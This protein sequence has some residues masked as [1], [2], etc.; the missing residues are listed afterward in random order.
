MSS[1]SQTGTL[2][3]SFSGSLPLTAISSSSSPSSSSFLS[4]S[5]PSPSSNDNNDD[6]MPPIS[7]S[8][9][10]LFGFL[11]TFLALFVGFM[12]CGY[13]SRRAAQLR[14]AGARTQFGD[15]GH[16]KSVKMKKPQLWDVRIAEKPG[17]EEWK[18]MTPLSA[19][20]LRPKISKKRSTPLPNAASE[21]PPALL[22]H[23][24]PQEYSPSFLFSSRSFGRPFNS[25]PPP[26]PPARR[27]HR[28]TSRRITT[29][30][31]ILPP[32]D[33]PSL[34]HRARLRN[35]DT[36]RNPELAPTN[37]PPTNIGA[38]QPK[39]VH[40]Q[41]SVLIAMPSPTS[42]SSA[43]KKSCA[44]SISDEEDEIVEIEKAR[45]LGD[46]EIGVARVRIKG[47]SD[48]TES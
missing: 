34:L 42:S 38:K 44:K 1:P 4:S 18:D 47:S 46:Y 17:V 45:L 43:F 33:L 13:S 39:D 20:V 41:V 31:F 28:S 29:A 6:G 48:Q 32:S 22:E 11:I 10:L 2:S 23:N 5:S 7:R 19:S 30:T 21:V 37:T 9:S 16:H 3:P 26:P 12:A 15:A 35:R 24:P 8:S 25:A 40:T 27:S 36:N 14:R